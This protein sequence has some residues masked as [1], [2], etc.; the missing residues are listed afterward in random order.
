MRTTSPGLSALVETAGAG[1]D[2]CARAV[3]VG[4]RRPSSR[5]AARS[6]FMGA[7]TSL[8]TSP[9]SRPHPYATPTPAARTYDS[10]SLPA[11]SGRPGD[12]TDGSGRRTPNWSLPNVTLV[13]PNHAKA[14]VTCVRELS[15]AQQGHK[16]RHS[17]LLPLSYISFS[18][19][20][21]RNRTQPSD[22]P[23]ASDSDT[24]VS[25]STTPLLRKRHTYAAPASPPAL[26]DW[27]INR[28]SLPFDFP[29][30]AGLGAQGVGTLPRSLTGSWTI[31]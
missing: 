28:L 8:G 25:Y 29:R 26:A 20:H 9:R 16:P 31:W 7:S 27:R 6:P 23:V 14:I 21:L 12:L 11:A 24:T 2:D 18:S 17:T 13:E 3:P 10:Y 4:P 22:W 30:T 19:S 1:S 5:S 15:I